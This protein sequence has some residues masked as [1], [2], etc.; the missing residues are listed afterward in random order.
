MLR[1]MYS[2]VAG[3]KVHQT[4]M[5]VIG[6]NIANVNT[7][8]Y[9]YQSINFSDVMYQTSQ[10]ASGA[11]ATTGG[12]NARQVGLGAINAAIST[13]IDQ[14]GATQTTNNPF[15]M[16]ISGSSFFIV[17]DGAGPKYT[18]DGSFYID[19]EGNLAMQ[20][21]GYYVMGWGTYEDENGALQ[22]DKNGGIGRMA[23]NT[24]EVQTYPAEATG[25]GTF[26][27]NIDR[28]DIDVTSSAGKTV[29]YE[30]YD[31]KGYIYT[32]DFIV[33]DVRQTVGTPPDEQ[34][35]I[36][37]GVYSL[38]LKDI[39]NSSTGQSITYNPEDPN[40]PFTFEQLGINFGGNDYTPTAA[41]PPQPIGN[42]T[43]DTNTIVLKF[44]DTTGAYEG[45]Y[46]GATG[47]LS[48]GFQPDG[49]LVDRGT[50]ETGYMKQ[51]LTFNEN[52][53]AP[54]GVNAEAWAA[55]QALIAS[56][57]TFD[58][59]KYTPIGTDAE[60]RYI[61]FDF[62]TITNNNTDGR[63]T[64]KTAKGNIN[65][66]V[67]G[68]KVGTLSGIQVALDGKVTA[69]YTNGQ[70]RLMGQIAAA[71]FANASGLEKQGENLYAATMNSGDAV[72][73]DVSEDGGKMSTGV[74]EMSNVDLSNEFTSMITAQRGFQANSRIITVSD[75]LL[76][77]LTNLKR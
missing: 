70:T 9:K 33:K 4:R 65:S 24:V 61:E 76:E 3:L 23:L 58:Q 37:P 31:D 15:D 46:T 51:L 27:G 39:V 11:T 73:M 49:T 17:N 7:T 75:T 56:M 45:M 20:S 42:T 12:V 38:T 28:N 66:G 8:A 60:P 29:Q 10:R 59:G 40:T 13:A 22:V 14:Q 2:G 32:A 72:V 19:G 18:R 5:D 64:I 74:L 52:T 48:A 53:T 67:T 54:A 57:G 62:S 6:N 26:S 71:Q 36:M 50:I 21:T 1:S 41:T 47:S 77:E 43:N 55:K 44:N 35:V 68:R 69:S 63:A 34:E 30:F 16:Q 25:A